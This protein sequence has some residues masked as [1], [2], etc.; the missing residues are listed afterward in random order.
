MKKYEED[1]TAVL[2]PNY[3]HSKV[4][5]V[6]QEKTLE[7]YLVTCSQMFYGLTPKNVEASL[8][9]GHKNGSL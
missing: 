6:E 1:P 7:D 9:N 3:S 8:R 2:A 5:T 4:F